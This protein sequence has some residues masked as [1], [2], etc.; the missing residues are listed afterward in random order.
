MAAAVWESY[1]ARV[2]DAVAGK[3][4]SD[5]VP[6]DWILGDRILDVTLLPIFFAFVFVA[7]RAVAVKFVFEPIG[8]RVMEGRMKKTDRKWDEP[9]Q[10]EFM[11]KWKESSWKCFIYIFFTIFVFAATVTKPFFWDPSKF[12]EGATKFPLNYYIP[13]EHVLFYTMQLGFYLQVC[14]AGPI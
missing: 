4:W 14:V 13:L 5:G 11:R 9:K 10:A 8:V 7:L 2:A 12:W 3:P 1:R 6:G